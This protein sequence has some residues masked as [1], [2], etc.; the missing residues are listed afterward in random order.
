MLSFETFGIFLFI[1]LFLVVL[2]FELRASSLLGVTP[3][4]L[5]ILLK[6]LLLLLTLPSPLHLFLSLPPVLLLKKQLY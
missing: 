1:Y 4:V 6:T 3:P 5:G 2:G